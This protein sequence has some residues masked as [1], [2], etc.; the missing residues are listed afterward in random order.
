ME[1][2]RKAKESAEL[3]NRSKS[4]FL[5]AMS[6]ELRTPLNA[7]IGFSTMIK[8]QMLGPNK[9]TVYAEYGT[10]IF[11]SGRH[12]LRLINDL[13]DLSK[14]E[15]GKLELNFDRLDPKKAIMDNIRTIDP[16][17]ARSEVELKTDFEDNLPPLHADQRAFDQIV[18]NIMSNAIKFTPPGGTVNVSVSAGPDNTRITVSDTGI[19]IEPEDLDKVMK[20]WGQI[21][22]PLKAD[23]KGSGLGLPIVKS[24]ID[25]HGGELSLESEV[26]T[27]TTIT[28]TLSN[29]GPKSG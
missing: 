6:H 28:I 16:I 22:D 7:I 26:G 17:A 13:L 25:L 2:L 29:F 11:N 23:H 14:I 15:A 27:G 3:A 5:A 10:D 9:A 1:E 12:L 20:P 21:I 19:G 8:D 24:L 4:D 18:L